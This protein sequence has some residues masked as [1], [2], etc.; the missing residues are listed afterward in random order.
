MTNLRA[1]QVTINPDMIN[2]GIGQPAMDILP[3]DVMRQAS[4]HRLSQPDIDW[5]NYGYESGDQT[6]LTALSH[7]LTPRHG[8]AVDPNTLF[9]TAG[10]SQALDLIC[11]T[12]TQ[13]GQTIFVE[14]PSYFLALGIF[15][16]HH[17]NVVSIP[18]DDE[19]LDLD[20][21]EDALSQHQPAFLYTIPT[22]QNPTTTTLSEWRRQKLVELSQQHNFLIVADEVYQLLTYTVDAPPPLAAYIESNQVISVNSFSK[23][24]APSLRLGWIQTSSE[25]I[26]QL[27]QNG[28]VDSGGSLNQYTSNIV[29]SVIELGL[30]DDYLAFLKGAY[31]E[32]M[33]A[34]SGALRSHLPQIDFMEPH[35]GFFFWFKLAEDVDTAQILPEALAQQV[36]FQPGIK[37]SSQNGL[38]NY[39][40]LSFAFYS[41]AEIEEGVGR[42]S[43]VLRPFV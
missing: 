4:Q 21:L 11:N 29:R 31:L 35:G 26:Q 1:T 13:P 17:L 18:L 8:G 9:V 5:L 6:F 22:C 14:E 39:I 19:G 7:F 42:L 32:R 10:A 37:F 12:F 16:N 24:L 25:M 23:I 36:G 2:F 43:G 3:L 41:V 40:R 38:N 28:V 15:A 33:T 27:L 34:M 20:A 30:L